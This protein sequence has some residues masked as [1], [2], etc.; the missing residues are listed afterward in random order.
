MKSFKY[1]RCMILQVIYLECLRVYRK[2]KLSIIFCIRITTQIVMSTIPKVGYK[3]LL[4]AV[5]SPVL[6]HWHSGAGTRR[7]SAA[8]R[9]AARSL[10]LNKYLIRKLDPQKNKN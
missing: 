4:W 2:L 8:L 1:I 6:K 9:C 7:L 5:L 10:T 3:L